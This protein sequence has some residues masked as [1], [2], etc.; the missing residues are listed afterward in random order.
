MQFLALNATATATTV[1]TTVSSQ[2]FTQTEL[3][4]AII[5]GLVAAFA[6]SML[7]TFLPIT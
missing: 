6:Y 5:S 2:G 4:I 1:S 3:G 7:E